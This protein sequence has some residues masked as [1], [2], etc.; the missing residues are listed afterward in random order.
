MEFRP[1]QPPGPESLPRLPYRPDS[2]GFRWDI[3]PDGVDIPS[4]MIAIAEAM[5]AVLSPKEIASLG[6]RLLLS[7]DLRSGDGSFSIERI[8]EAG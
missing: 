4:A 7:I 6:P 3:D 1:K 5:K 2:R 8:E